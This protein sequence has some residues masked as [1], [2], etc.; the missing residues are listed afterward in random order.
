MDSFN[1]SSGVIRVYR[2]NAF[3]RVFSLVFSGF[4]AIALVAIWFGVPSGNRKPNF[5]EIIVPLVLV[6]AGVFFSV[7]AFLNSITLTSDTVE[8]KSLAGKRVLPFDRIRGRR[9]YLDKGDA[10]SP[11]IWRLVLESNDDRFPRIDIQETYNF[12]DFFY[13]WFNTL[14]DLDVL[15]KSKPKP[16][17]FGLI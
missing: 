6:L 17:N 8:V 9:R 5:V 14:R 3:Q 13:Q 10:D 16:S 15:D 7:R 11:S 2:M 12:D 1:S 4:Y